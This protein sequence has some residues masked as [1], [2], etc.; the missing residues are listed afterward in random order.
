VRTI[1]LAFATMAL[2]AAQAEDPIAIEVKKLAGHWECI[3]HVDSG[4][5][6]ENLKIKLTFKGNKIYV[7]GE[8]IK[9]EVSEASFA[10]DPTKKPKEIDIT[11]KG[12]KVPGIYHLDGDTLKLA[13]ANAQ[14]RDMRPTDFEGKKSSVG[15]FKRAKK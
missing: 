4:R 9:I 11:A 2:S 1:E 13:T 15:V 14:S 10:I 3:R 7:T 6:A 5:T 12:V 8:G